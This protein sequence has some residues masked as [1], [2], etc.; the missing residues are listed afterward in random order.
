LFPVKLRWVSVEAKR[1]RRIRPGPAVSV[2]Q[3]SIST[4]GIL[5]DPVPLSKPTIRI[6]PEGSHLH[7]TRSGPHKSPS[8]TPNASFFQPS[9]NSDLLREPKE[10][11]RTSENTYRLC[12][13]PAVVRAV[14]RHW[15]R[16][17]EALFGKFHPPVRLA[18]QGRGPSMID[19]AWSAAKTNVNI[20]AKGYL[21]ILD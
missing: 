14:G 11:S 12:R 19:L 7:P 13:N 15:P 21:H 2:Q 6:K 17:W 16:L 1:I 18:E 9:C 5:M 20:T 3:P 10:F 8:A 4:L